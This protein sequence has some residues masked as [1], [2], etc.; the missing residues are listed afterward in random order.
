MPIVA[1]LHFFPGIMKPYISESTSVEIADAHY[2]CDLEMYKYS[3]ERPLSRFCPQSAGYLY[4][5][6]PPAEARATTSSLCRL[7][8]LFL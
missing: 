3:D 7:I 2:F 1:T 5:R 4:L 6:A 8:L